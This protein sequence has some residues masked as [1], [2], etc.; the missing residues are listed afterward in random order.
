MSY[1]PWALWCATEGDILQDTTM[2]LFT[3]KSLIYDP[4]QMT[5]K[6]CL[7]TRM[8]KDKWFSQMKYIISIYK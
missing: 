7:L 8:D 6:V 4:V 3:K 5:I 1:V 2:K